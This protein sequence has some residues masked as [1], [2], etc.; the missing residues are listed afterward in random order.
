MTFSNMQSTS[1][2]KNI[3]ENQ[4]D[5]NYFDVEKCKSSP[6]KNGC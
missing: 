2:Q 4:V 3:G 6:L 1:G 5:T